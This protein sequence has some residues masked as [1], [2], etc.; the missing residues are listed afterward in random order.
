[1]LP[2]MC[3]CLAFNSTIPDIT[4]AADYKKRLPKEE[5]SAF[6]TDIFVSNLYQSVLHIKKQTAFVHDLQKPP[7]LL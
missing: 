5:I 4:R 3:G 1:M 7:V 6:E 2:V